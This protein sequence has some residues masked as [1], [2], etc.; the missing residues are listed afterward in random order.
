MPFQIGTSSVLNPDQ[1]Y[2]RLFKD[3]LDFIRGSHVGSGTINAGGAGYV[4][5]D[6]LGITG[7]TTFGTSAHPAEF[8]V[9]TEAAGV[10]TALRLNNSGSYII[11]PAT[12]TGNALVGGTGAGATVDLIMDSW[13]TAVP[14]AGGTG[15]V[16][17]EI[18]TLVG[19][20]VETTAGTFEVLTE[21]AGVVLTVKPVNIGD[22]SEL[23]TSPVATT[24]SASGTGATLDLTRSGWLM[25][26][27]TYTDDQT[28][29]EFWAEGVNNSGANPFIGAFTE[30]EG[31]NPQWMLAGAS[32][33][34]GA[35]L[36]EDQPGISP[37]TAMS[38]SIPSARVPLT[39]SDLDFFF[40]VTPRRFIMVAH[41][42]STYEMIYM[43]LFVPFI[44]DPASKWPLPLFIAGTTQRSS[45]LISTT[46]GGLHTTFLVEPGSNQY[47][48]RDQAGNWNQRATGNTA[49]D[50]WPE[51]ALNTLSN[52]VET[53]AP[54]IATGS[55]TVSIFGGLWR[56]QH[57]NSTPG[58]MGFLNVGVGSRLYFL[59]PFTFY[60][61]EPG[62]VQV[63]GETD[64]LF[65]LAARDLIAE[66][67]IV[68]QLGREH[69]V[70]PNID[71]TDL[72]D[73]YTVLME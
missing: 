26:N 17:G 61:D 6:I 10:I 44:T 9:I 65:K 63:L 3:M 52:V 49:W 71:Q 62:A 1:A 51:Q 30:T 54:N 20:T 64:G 4:V 36:W 31:G 66:N 15:Y 33:F 13:V 41:S 7:G 19:G 23:P 43:G 14:N 37:V 11:E 32:G 29:A 38:N 47:F 56:D 39:V 28:D 59:L 25:R 70:F 60:Q 42:L 58:D 24:A 16:V 53:R 27:T 69:M 73:F 2:I 5:G 45:E 48:L 34:N 46:Q 50:Q 18:L 12:L 22:Y 8:E 72:Q 40:F 55:G 67:I 21:A 68:D 35:S 57:Y